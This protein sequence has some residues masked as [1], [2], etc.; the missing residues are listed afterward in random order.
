MRCSGKT[1]LK[2]KIIHETEIENL[3]RE[4]RQQT[5]KFVAKVSL[6][7]EFTRTKINK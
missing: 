2:L 4:D 3:H 6:K 7:P 1:S 5:T